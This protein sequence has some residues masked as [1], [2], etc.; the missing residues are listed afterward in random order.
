MPLLDVSDLLSD[1]DIA[2]QAFTVV[3]NAVTV[4]MD[5]QGVASPQTT[6]AIGS[7]Q[8]AKSSDVVRMPDGTWQTGTIVVRTTFRLSS[9]D[10]NTKP[11]IIVLPSGVRYFVQNTDDWSDFGVGFVTAM[12]SLADVNPASP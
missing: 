11:D 5:G 10:A 2:G 12:A 6:N 8:P 9:G 3:R 1:P 4:G 7:V